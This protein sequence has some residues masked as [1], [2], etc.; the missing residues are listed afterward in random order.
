MGHIV[1]PKGVT[2]SV[3]NRELSEDEKNLLSKVIREE[4]A[5]PTPSKGRERI[6]IDIEASQKH[7]LIQLFELLNIKIVGE[8]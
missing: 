6:T 2:L 1:E 8:A 7:V 5:S 3:I 4:R